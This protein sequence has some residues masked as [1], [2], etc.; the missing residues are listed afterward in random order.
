MKNESHKSQF[1]SE[2][3][4]VL[5]LWTW[6]RA[7]LAPSSRRGVLHKKEKKIFARRAKTCWMSPLG[8]LVVIN[9]GCL[10]TQGVAQ[11]GTQFFLSL[12]QKCSEQ[13]HP[14]WAL[15]EKSLRVLHHMKWCRSHSMER[16]CEWHLRVLASSHFGVEV[17][18]WS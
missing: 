4:S 18:H 5:R 1:P 12:V 17:T 6:P 14:K 11:S 16:N 9:L 3:K 7:T 8:C 10:S 2:R 13:V 15:T